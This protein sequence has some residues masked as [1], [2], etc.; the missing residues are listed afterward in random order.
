[1][2][3]K[4]TSFISFCLLTLWLSVQ[5]IDAWHHIHEIHESDCTAETSHYC[6]PHAELELCDLCTIV[7]GATDQINAFEEPI[8]YV[9][10]V[11]IRVVKTSPALSNWSSTIVSRG[12]P[13]LV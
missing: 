9:T 10:S 1:M 4:T 3:K 11:E 12:P 5:C 7:H 2:V 8:L 13:R 6:E